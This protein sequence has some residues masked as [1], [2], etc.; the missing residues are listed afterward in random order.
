MADPKQSVRAHVALGSNLGDRCAHLVAALDALG[1][2]PECRIVA[3]SRVY[4]TAP[5]GPPQ[6]DY[7]NAAIAVD[8]RLTARALLERLQAIEQ[9]RG[10]ER[11]VPL[12]PRTLDLDLLLYGDAVIDEPGLQVPH[13]RMHE[14]AFVL[15][16]LAE[17]AAELHHPILGRSIRELAERVR[18]SAATRIRE[19]EAWQS[20]P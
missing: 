6:G 4:E 19:E 11:S 16:P 14:R 13:P 5:V 17:V 9:E 8:T 1:G 15:E 7:L 12:G 2:T 20:W 3:R 18:D 10:R